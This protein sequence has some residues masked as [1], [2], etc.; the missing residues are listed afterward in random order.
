MPGSP[1]TR[2]PPSDEPLWLR[3]MDG[4]VSQPWGRGWRFEGFSTTTVRDDLAI[5]YAQLIAH[6]MFRSG[7]T[8]LQR[9]AAIGMAARR[10][11]LASGAAPRGIGVREERAKLAGL[12]VYCPA[13]ATTVDH[14][15]PRFQTGPDSADNLVPACRGCN[16]SKRATDVFVWAAGKGFFPLG[17]VRRYLVL[18]WRW[19]ERVGVLD[20]AKEGSGRRVDAVPA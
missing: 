4:C 15:V 14:L 12:C 1:R 13:S 19:S 3:G 7:E 16:S 2:V 8:E 17:I 18:A 5:A 20:Q 10:R 6:R 9:C 11:L